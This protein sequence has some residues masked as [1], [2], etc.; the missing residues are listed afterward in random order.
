LISPS[1]TPASP[2]CWP[3]RS[4]KPCC[5]PGLSTTRRAFGIA[6]AAALVL[7]GA[8]L[9]LVDSEPVI[10]AATAVAGWGFIVVLLGVAQRARM[11]DGAALAYLAESSFPIYVLHQVG[12]VVTGFWIIQL[13][14]G[15]AAKFVLVLVAAV[16][17]TLAFYHFV[18]R[19][20]PALRAVLGMKAA[21]AMR[22]SASAAR[23][24]QGS[25][26]LETCRV[27]GPPV[28]SMIRRRAMDS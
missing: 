16:A 10:L 26:R 27:P 6:L 28:G 20:V 21:S 15:I 11:R 12:I 22:A 23:R 18:V 2:T 8:V 3:P 13:P 7:L 4:S 1:S 14:L 9:Q 19:R 17:S 24:A 25:V 5:A